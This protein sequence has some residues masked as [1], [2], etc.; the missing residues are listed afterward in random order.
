M[1]D[2][3]KNFRD[4]GYQGRVPGENPPP[5]QNAPLGRQRSSSSWIGAAVIAVLLLIAVGYV[6]NNRTTGGPG[7]IEHRAAATDTATP[8]GPAMTPSN[9]PAAPSA[10]PKP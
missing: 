10:S 7:L 2:Y 6:F 4:P 1:S 3:D 5:G 8:A 9:A